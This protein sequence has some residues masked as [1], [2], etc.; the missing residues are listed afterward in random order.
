M[1]YTTRSVAGVCL[2]ATRGRLDALTCGPLQRALADEIENGSRLLVFDCTQLEYVSSAGLGVFIEAVKRLSR[3]G[4]RAAFAAVNA[5]VLRVFEISGLVPLFEV[6][7]TVE[8]AVSSLGRTQS[9]LGD[10]A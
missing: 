1:Q 4:G 7:P 6:L 2:V 3:M 9:A 5:R 10:S 8:E